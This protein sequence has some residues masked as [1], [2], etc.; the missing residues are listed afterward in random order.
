MKTSRWRK[1]GVA[2]GLFVLLLCLIVLI[3]H[4]NSKG[5]MER[6]KEQLRA[7]GEKLTVAELVPLPPSADEDGTPIFERISS[8]ESLFPN[9][10]VETNPPVN[11]AV[12]PGKWMIA[13]QQAQ[14][15]DRFVTPMATNTWE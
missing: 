8:M 7:A 15:V 11:W 4:V 6:Y 10:V 5:P 3:A 13:R 1:V 12:A 9:D 14:I 2:F